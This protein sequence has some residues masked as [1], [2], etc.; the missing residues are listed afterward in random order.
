MKERRIFEAGGRKRVT[1]FPKSQIL[2]EIHRPI[3]S[4]FESDALLR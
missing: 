3:L 4:W 1:P 2:F